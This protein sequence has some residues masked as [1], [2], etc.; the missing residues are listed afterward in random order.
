ML[1]EKVNKIDPDSDK[2]TLLLKSIS[3]ADFEHEI[4]DDVDCDVYLLRLYKDN[5]ISGS[6]FISIYN[7]LMALMEYGNQPLKEKDQEQYKFPLLNKPSLEPLFING[8]LNINVKDHFDS[9]KWN[10]N[11]WYGKDIDIESMLD[12]CKSITKAESS[13]ICVKINNDE[14]NLL[15]KLT[16]SKV[17][18][19][20][21]QQQ[22]GDHT[23][24]YQLNFTLVEYLNRLINEPMRY[25]GVWP[26]WRCNIKRFA[27]E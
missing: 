17:G 20:S 11:N 25:C 7:Y 19:F 10:F 18:L 12:F 2:L 14:N 6:V 27:F 23:L 15:E 26:G 13:F 24:F 5:K 8:E 22:I 3:D 1:D 9:I 4:Y 16:Q 21:F